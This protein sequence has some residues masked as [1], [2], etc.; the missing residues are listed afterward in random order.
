MQILDIHRQ[1]CELLND[2]VAKK[3]P[4]KSSFRNP[5]FFIWETAVSSQI[6]KKNLL[7]HTV[8]HKKVHLHLKRGITVFENDLKCLI[9]FY[10]NFYWFECLRYLWNDSIYEGLG[11]HFNITKWDFLENFQTPCITLKLV[12]W[13]QI[14]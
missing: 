12:F 7:Q 1:L 9:S 3:G 13:W 8:R 11:F 6:D 10:E 14:Q 5:L 4:N 2:S